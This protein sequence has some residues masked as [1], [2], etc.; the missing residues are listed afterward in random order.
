MRDGGLR[1]RKTS[2]ACL[3]DCPCRR[4]SND[5]WEERC[6]WCCVRRG[7]WALGKLYGPKPLISDASE[8]TKPERVQR[9]RGNERKAN[10]LLRV[11]LCSSVSSVVTY[12]SFLASPA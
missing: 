6:A 4:Q 11:P 12:C 5:F 2:G 3:Q 8:T 10:S 7:V 9:R 1:Q